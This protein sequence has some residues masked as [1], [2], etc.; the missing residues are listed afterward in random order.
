MKDIGKMRLGLG[1]WSGL[2]HKYQCELALL[3]PSPGSQGATYKYKVWMR[4]RYRSCCNRLE[5]LLTHPSFQ[6]KVS[7]WPSFSPHL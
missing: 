6:V 2:G 4:H 3:T 5:E 7:L 1:P